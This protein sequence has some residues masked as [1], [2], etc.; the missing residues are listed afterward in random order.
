LASSSLSTDIKK[1]GNILKRSAS[2]QII[3]Y[4][5][6]FQSIRDLFDK[7]LANLAVSE[8]DFKNV[9]DTAIEFFGSSRVKFAAVDGTEYT[10]PMF[11]LVIFFSD[12]CAAKGFIEFRERVP[13]KVEYLS[14]L[15]GQERSVCSC[16]PVFVNKV[17][18]IDQTMLDFREETQTSVVRP[19][20]NESI[21]VNSS[22]ASWVMAFAEVY[23]GYRLV[24]DP[25]EDIG[26]LL[27]DRSLTSMQTSLMYDTSYRSKWERKGSLIGY[28]VDGV[29]IDVNDLAFG[30]HRI[31]NE[32]LG[33]PAPRGDY[34]RYAIIYLLEK[35][36]S[37]LTFDEIC[38]ELDI[39]DEKR[40]ERVSRF[41]KK[42]VKEGFVEEKDG[43]FSISP[44]YKNTWVRLKKLVS[45][46]GEQLLE[47]P[48]VENP[49]KITKKGG[50]HW[51]TTL[52]LAFMTLLCLYMLIEECWKRR[53]LLIGVTKDTASRD[54]KNQVV[55]V[56]VNNSIWPAID[57]V[58]LSQ[59]PN[60]DRMFL[61]SISLFNHDRLPAPWSLV[62]YD[63]A[64]R[65]IVP[66]FKKR[67]GFVSG[68]IKNRIIPE[69]LFVKSYVQLSQAEYDPQLRSNV[70]FIDRL[71]YPEFD[72]RDDSTVTFK[73]E[74]VAIEPVRVILFKDKMVENRVQNL[75]MVM[76]KAMTSPSIPEV[77][78]HNKPLF[79][80]D[81]VA[82][83]H[84]GEA[85]KIIETAKRW[86]INNRDLRKF[87]FY[88][89]TFRERRNQVEAARRG[90]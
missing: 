13:P 37:G 34:L 67:A 75:V 79:I 11:D 5:N 32:K 47:R 8:F 24:S 36:E 1:T 26:I 41:V 30:R 84:Y 77:F 63:S 68:A 59:A 7:L 55:P 64:F 50:E 74:Y 35:K 78:G 86:I 23:L 87:V 46:L 45:I 60:T 42:S 31:L 10:R 6:R 12:A 66:D 22:I 19:L 65:T 89:S 18:E 16:V 71:V 49:L 9:Y 15:V 27:L 21:A 80:A 56:C 90:I 17:A 43:R 39:T 28:E 54:F 53:V 29:P 88:M 44:R 82:K 48:D 69:R 25:A 85:R 33:I 52:D 57:Q 73:H 14:G 20:T 51:L 70:L 76:L 83:W 2:D 4:K 81:K 61:Q 62:E 38:R 40:K 72:L 58:K 3:D